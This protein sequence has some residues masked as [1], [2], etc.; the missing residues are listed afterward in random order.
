MQ[1]SI[2][3]PPRRKRLKSVTF[4]ALA[5]LYLGAMNLARAWL[6]LESQPFTRTLPLAIPLPYLAAS[7]LI[8][9]LVFVVAAFGVW[10]LWPWARALLLGAI[11][12]YQLHIWA[13]HWIFDTSSYSRQVWPFHA[14]ISVAWVVIIWGFSFLPSIRRLYQPQ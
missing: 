13:N 11:V 9:G 3:T 14:G 8:W 7:A 1:N 2:A 4:L 12:L 10:R 5:V 6:A